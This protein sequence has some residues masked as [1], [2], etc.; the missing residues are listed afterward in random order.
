[1]TAPSAAD[2]YALWDGTAWTMTN[3]IDG[4]TF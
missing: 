1:M 2:Q 3:V 4:G